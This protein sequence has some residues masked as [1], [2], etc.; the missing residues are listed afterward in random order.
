[1]TSKSDKKRLKNDHIIFVL[2][3]SFQKKREMVGTIR[4]NIKMGTQAIC[5]AHGTELYKVWASNL[6]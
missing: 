2:I 4:S 5:V 6:Q 1:M 3:F